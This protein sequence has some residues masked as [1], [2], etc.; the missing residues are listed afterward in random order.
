MSW[1]GESSWDRCVKEILEGVQFLVCNRAGRNVLLTEKDGAYRLPGWFSDNL[2]YK[3]IDAMNAA[4]EDLF[5]SVFRGSVLQ[6][7]WL[8]DKC[9]RDP[10]NELQVLQRSVVVLEC[11]RVWRKFRRDSSQN[12]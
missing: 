4:I 5:G 7:I 8:W 6:C 3:N 10:K 12:H 1:S 11:Q 9:F 2:Y